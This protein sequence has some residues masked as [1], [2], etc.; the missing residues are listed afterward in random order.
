MTVQGGKVTVARH[1]QLDYGAGGTACR[2]DASEDVYAEKLLEL[3]V[4]ATRIRLRSDVPV[5]A[6]L[7]GDWT[8]HSSPPSSGSSPWPR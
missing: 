3:L 6:Y 5:G 2:S 8:R 4:D 7:S 1:W